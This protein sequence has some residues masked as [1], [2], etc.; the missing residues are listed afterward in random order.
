MKKQACVC[1][2]T[3]VA[4]L[5]GYGC[6]EALP[7]S[8]GMLLKGGHVIDPKNEISAPMDVA[9]DEGKIVAVRE[10]L[11]EDRAGKVVDVSGLYVTPGL[12]DLHAH[13]YAGTGIPRV[14]TGDSSV[15]PDH[16]SFR[17]GCT[18]LVDVGSSGQRN[19]E[20]FKDRVIDRSRTRVLV[21]LNI[22]GGGMGPDGEDN[23]E[24][25]EPEKIAAMAKKYPDIIVGVKT[26]H[27]S[28]PEWVSVERAVEA[29]DLVD[30]PV[31]VDF[32]A[33]HP[34][35]R[36]IGELYLEKLRP[37]DIYTHMYSGLRVELTDEGKINP[38]MFQGRERGIIFDIGHGGGSFTW[39][40][41]VPAY[42]QGFPPDTISTD[43]HTGSMN[44]GM[45]DMTNVMSK[46]LNLGSSLEEV[47]RMSTWKPAEVIKRTE[48]GHLSEGAIADV[49]VLRLDEGDFGFLDVRRITLKG[50]KLLTAELT[51]KGGHVEWDLNG[52]AGEDWK[53]FY[54]DEKN[55]V[56]P[57][58]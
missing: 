20:D 26:A 9:I 17:S 35:E 34:K 46:I 51:I 25:M 15:Y 18:T 1:L 14:L 44:A 41:A 31:M 12:I 55:R 57:W 3:V 43:L 7:E 21:M 29:A 16:F 36:P 2:L 23:P 4:L 30:I 53:T 45:K 54:A 40:V 28:G 13:V 47:V 56:D 6:G 27:Y 22:A 11:P 37:G 52:R 58:R 42:E 39:R 10:S 33:N 5:A 8:Y 32:G 50:N 48:L 24:D 49:T 38:S 19:F